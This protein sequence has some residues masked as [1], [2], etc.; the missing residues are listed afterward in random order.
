MCVC[1]HPR[2]RVRCVLTGASPVPRATPVASTLCIARVAYMPRTARGIQQCVKEQK[3]KKRN[4]H[5]TFVFCR[6]IRVKSKAGPRAAACPRAGG[7]PA[8]GSSLATSRR[9][10]NDGAVCAALIKAIQRA[11]AFLLPPPLFAE[12]S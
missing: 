7:G 3:K 6:T 8:E 10:C 4:L 11:T 1:A 5:G 2:A 9:L 12:K